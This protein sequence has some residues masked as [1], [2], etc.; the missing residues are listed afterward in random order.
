M[1]RYS[2]FVAL[3]PASATIIFA[4]QPHHKD[5]SPVSVGLFPLAFIIVAH[6]LQS[7]LYASYLSISSFAGSL[8]DN[9]CI[10][11][12]VQIIQCHSFLTLKIN[13]WAVLTASSWNKTCFLSAMAEAWLSLCPV[14]YP[15]GEFLSSQAAVFLAQCSRSP[16]PQHIQGF[17]EEVRL[18][19]SL[20]WATAFRI[21]RLK[22]QTVNY[23]TFI[24]PTIIQNSI[25]FI[26]QPKRPAALFYN[27]KNSE[28]LSKSG[29]GYDSSLRPVLAHPLYTTHPMLRV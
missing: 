1:Y 21:W 10:G 14:S 5:N 3:S 2:P 29:L 9:S 16:F 25:I 12:H 22:N 15:K 23:P 28:G 24:S 4:P 27:H 11:M 18:W 26:I 20:S 6:I 19:V 8:C 7:R 17:F 13:W